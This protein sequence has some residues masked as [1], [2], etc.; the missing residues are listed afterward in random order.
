MLYSAAV[1]WAPWPLTSTIRFI[2][3]VAWRMPSPLMVINVLAE[4]K[5]W[6]CSYGRGRDCG[7]NVLFDVL[8]DHVGAAE[9]IDVAR[10]GLE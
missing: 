7:A 9:L 3:R 8:N 4:A 2:Q 1:P 5:L 10:S 6:L